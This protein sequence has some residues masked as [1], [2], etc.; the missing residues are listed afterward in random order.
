MR[1]I[2]ADCEVVYEGRGL[3]TLSRAKRAII[4]KSDGAVSVHSSFGNKPLNYMGAGTILTV[5]KQGRKQVWVF[6]SKKESITVSIFKIIDDNEYVLEA[7][8][9][10]VVR[11]RTENELQAWLAKHPEAVGRGFK[12]VAREYRTGVGSVDLLMQDVDGSYVAVEVKRKAMIDA[13]YQVIRYVDFLNDAGEHG[14]VRG[15]I[16]A[17]DVR[18]N[19]LKLAAARGVEC[20]ELVNV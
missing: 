2:V 4:I 15:V 12:F 10:G 13:V 8:D 1:V 7:H 16:V 11:Y 20:V 19:T 9:D 17:L 14:I 5:K 6:A 18:P 3:T